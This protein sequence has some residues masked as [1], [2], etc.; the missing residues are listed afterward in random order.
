MYSQLNRDS[1]KCPGV[2]LAYS[3]LYGITGGMN[4]VVAPTHIHVVDAT[5][6]ACALCR[7]TTWL[8]LGLDVACNEI[9][10]SCTYVFVYVISVSTIICIPSAAAC[11][12]SVWI[13]YVFEITSTATSPLPSTSASPIF[14][15]SAS[16]P[17]PSPS[18]SSSSSSTAAA[19][20]AS[21]C[22]T[23]LHDTG[24]IAPRVC[25]CVCMWAL[26]KCGNNRKHLSRCVFR[27][28][29][30]CCYCYRILR[31]EV[32]NCND[33]NEVPLLLIILMCHSLPVGNVGDIVSSSWHFWQTKCSDNQYK[34]FFP[35][36][37]HH[38][39]IFMSLLNE[40]TCIQVLRIDKWFP[41]AVH[42]LKILEW[43]SIYNT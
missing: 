43:F 9:W 27:C 22:C 40:H 19:A 23:S 31:N 33:C 21:L 32:H 25:V 5:F 13:L 37:I 30:C 15:S 16:S 1:N 11:I 26:I 10:E 6:C 2:T 24:N 35:Y 4:E 7:P 36:Q 42:W 14:H 41:V 29:S 3:H 38:K 8:N 20:T 18:S 39:L 34:L 28:C 17:S 12:Q